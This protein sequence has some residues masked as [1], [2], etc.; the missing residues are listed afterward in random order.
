MS[1]SIYVGQLSAEIKENDLRKLFP[2]AKQ[3]TLIAA[4]GTRPGLV[5]T[6]FVFSLRDVQRYCSRHAFVA[7]A[8]D[9]SAAAAVEKGAMF[10]NTQLK[11]A[12][13]T[14]RNQPEKRSSDSNENSGESSS[15]YETTNVVT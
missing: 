8:D 14:K 6:M 10:K 7:F 2:K 15:I 13:Q 1:D 11:V 5:S 4:E 9:V 3:I 12:F